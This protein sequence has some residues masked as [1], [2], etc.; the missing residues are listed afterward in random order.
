MKNI[1]VDR[2]MTEKLREID[3]LAKE[4]MVS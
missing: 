1:I 2:S 4:S 3:R